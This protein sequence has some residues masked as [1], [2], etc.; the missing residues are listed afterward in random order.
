MNPVGIFLV[1]GSLYLIVVAYGV[2][3][4]RRRGLPLGLRLMAAAL[5]IVLPPII[6]LAIMRLEPDIFPMG[7][8]APVLGMLMIAGALLA[9]CTDIV[10][11][12]IL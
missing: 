7:A 12:R 11:R 5:Q 1:I 2:V 6:L 9:L 10:A 4:T 8:W 3:G